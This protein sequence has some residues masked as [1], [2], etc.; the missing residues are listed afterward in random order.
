MEN[1]IELKD[2]PG[3][4]PTSIEKLEKAGIL[5]VISFA[6][7]SPTQIVD[8]SGIS[9]AAARKAILFAKDE[10]GL[11]FQRADEYDKKQAEIFFISTGSK[12]FDLLLGGGIRSSSITEA[13]AEAKVGKSQ[14][15][16]T[17]TA[18]TL[19]MGYKV[20]WLDTEGAY[21]SSRIREIINKKVEK[22]KEIYENGV[23]EELVVEEGKKP[24]KIK[25][26]DIYSSFE[27]FAFERFKF[28]RFDENECMK[29]M[30]VTNALNYELQMLLI[31]DVEKSISEGNEI[32]LL[33][34]DSFMQNFRTGFDGRGQLSDRQSFIKR[35]AKD[36][37]DLCIKH[38]IVIYATGQVMSNPG[39]LFGDPT[40]AI[41]GNVWAHNVTTRIYLR[42]AKAGSRM[43]KVVGSRDLEDGEAPFQVTERGIEDI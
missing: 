1:K 38:N 37:N 24:K 33:V 40:T 13:F 2:L 29:D 10:L 27:E 25:I 30:Y 15:G 6:S 17:L 26:K 41:G 7:R 5:D 31:E 35:H 22:L 43:A 14:L 4:G 42:R 21:R 32:K 12:E 28:K 34:I 8:A 3:I 20:F 36:L 39:Q 16:F 23:E 18:N 9:L 19:M 11:G